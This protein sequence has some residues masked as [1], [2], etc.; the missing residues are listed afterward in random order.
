MAVT[1]MH[2]GMWTWSGWPAQSWFKCLWTWYGYGARQTGLSIF[3][4]FATIPQFYFVYQCHRS[5]L[6]S[7]NE[8]LM[9]CHSGILQWLTSNTLVNRVDRGVDFGRT[10]N[11]LPL[12]IKN[13]NINDRKYS[14]NT[15]SERMWS[16]FF[17]SPPLFLN[18]YRLFLGWTCEIFSGKQNHITFATAILKQNLMWKLKS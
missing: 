7:F 15:T 9:L 5:Y 14:V 4:F 2:L 13:T 11:F 8:T 6:G 12:L 17:S 3:I 18:V 16:K 10:S 1:R